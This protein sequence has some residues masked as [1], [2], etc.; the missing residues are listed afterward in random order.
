MEGLGAEWYSPFDID[1]A[2]KMLGAMGKVLKVTR[3][4]L[5][6]VVTLSYCG[7]IT[8]RFGHLLGK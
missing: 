5:K 1:R 2:L 3:E 8:S 6:D 4:E 7:I